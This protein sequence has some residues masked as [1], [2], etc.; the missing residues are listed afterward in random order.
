MSQTASLLLSLMLNQHY[1][2]VRLYAIRAHPSLFHIYDFPSRRCHFL[3]FSMQLLI[4][5]LSC[6][7]YQNNIVS[8]MDDSVNKFG[9]PTARAVIYNAAPAVAFCALFVA[10]CAE[11]FFFRKRTRSL[12]LADG[13]RKAAL[14]VSGAVLLV[15]VSHCF[16]DGS[17]PNV[18]F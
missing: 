13:K 12:T 8:D 2:H 7:M 17:T 4:S 14:W 18:G 11:L 15:F 6:V 1:G 5:F 16:N 10:T 9:A 3:H